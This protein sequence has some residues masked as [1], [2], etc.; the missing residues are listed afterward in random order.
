M[1]SKA[2]FAL[3][4]SVTAKANFH[5]HAIPPALLSLRIEAATRNPEG[6]G[7]GRQ[8]VM[9]GLDVKLI[10]HYQESVSPCVAYPVFL[11]LFVPVCVPSASDFYSY[12]F[13][14]LCLPLYDF[15]SIC[16]VPAC[17]GGCG[18]TAD[19]GAFILIRYS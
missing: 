9:L 5:K 3:F 11:F 13:F 16:H 2:D 8:D 14:R 18:H 4:K 7:Y 19:R 12:P 15:L 17:H 10:F 6:C 1:E